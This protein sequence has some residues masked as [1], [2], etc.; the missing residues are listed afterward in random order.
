M[1]IIGN[2]P[3]KIRVYILYQDTF[4]R[5]AFLAVPPSLM[6]STAA[7]LFRSVRSLSLRPSVTVL[8]S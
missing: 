4:L 7:A 6:D 5:S 1:K 2:A 3:I 8:S